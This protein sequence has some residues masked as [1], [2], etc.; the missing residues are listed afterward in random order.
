MHYRVTFLKC[1]AEKREM[2][3]KDNQRARLTRMLFKNA[4]LELMEAGDRINVRALCE[5]AQLN[6]STFYLHYPG[7]IVSDILL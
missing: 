3:T 4:Y 6:R 7:V 5:K 2:N 1:V